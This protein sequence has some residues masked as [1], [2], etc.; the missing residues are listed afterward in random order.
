MAALNACFAAPMSTAAAPIAMATRLVVLFGEL[1]KNIQ[2][3]IEQGQQSRLEGF[4]TDDFEMWAGPRPGEPVPKADWLKESITHPEAVKFRHIEQ[5]VAKDFGD[6]VIVSFKW[7]GETDI[8][9]IDIW[10]KINGTW[11]LSTRYAG[12]AGTL[13]FD[14]PGAVYQTPGFQKKF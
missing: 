11:K 3:A 7:G 10:K 12:P 8:F 2:T 4:L 9:V 14:I 1:E 6:I 13:G 5:V